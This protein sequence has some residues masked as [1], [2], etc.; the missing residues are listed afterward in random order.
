MGKASMEALRK[1]VNKRFFEKNESKRSIMQELGLS[2]NFVRAW[3]QTK[4]QNF[5]ADGRGWKSG[6][7]R[8]HPSDVKARIVAIRQK[9]EKNPD[10]FFSGDLAI[11]QRYAEDHPSDPLP[12]IDY[13]NDIIRTA[14]LAK[15][16][17][18]KRRGTAVPYL[19]YPQFC[20]SYVG[21]RIADVDH[22]GHK[23]VR[24]VC[25]PMHF[26]SVAYRKP[27]RLRSIQRV[28]SETT[29][30]TV[31][32]LNGIFD[33]LGWPDAV[34][35]DVGTPFAGRTDRKDGKGARSVP[36]FAVNLLE[37]R[38]VPIYGNPRSP[39]NQGTGEG[40]NSVFG[41]N[42]WDANEYTSVAMIDER[43]VAF[44]ASAK[45]YA[46]YEPWIR[47]KKDSFVPRI[48]FI[49]RAAED[50]RG[51]NGIIPVAGEWIVLPK[52]YVGYYTFSEWDLKE[53][54]LQV[55][56]EREGEVQK[57]EERSFEIHSRSLQKCTHFIA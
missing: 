42:F 37:H 24:G 48:C 50:T 30:E 21:E 23:F 4:E 12:G 51:K 36:Q 39:W 52:E 18:K 33:D 44:N 10:E 25:E 45:K 35:T 38:T 46:R 32:V 1:E 2:W 14:G 19:C 29:E 40:S 22:I 15:H 31:S 49:R 16:H 53:Q 11:Q 9:L 20:I 57:I 3:T 54:K 13:I 56:F 41:R 6:V 43:L 28:S 8:K 55:F 17:H 47:E 27:R 7:A 5:S 34:K 26:L